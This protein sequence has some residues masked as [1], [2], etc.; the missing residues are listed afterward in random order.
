MSCSVAFCEIIGD[1]TYVWNSYSSKVHNALKA[2]NVAT[3]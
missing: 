3:F 2:K 1:A